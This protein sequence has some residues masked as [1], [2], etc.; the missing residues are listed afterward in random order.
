MIRQILGWAIV[1]SPLVFFVFLAIE[2]WD[3]G[4]DPVADIRQRWQKH[5]YKKTHLDFT[6]DGDD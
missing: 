2:L 5:S 3:D 4:Y 1:L 6:P